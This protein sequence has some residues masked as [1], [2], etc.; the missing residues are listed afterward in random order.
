MAEQPSEWE[1][2]CV[3]F[4]LGAEMTC[5]LAVVCVAVAVSV[6]G[7]LSPVEAL[8]ALALSALTTIH[9]TTM[10]LRVRAAARRSR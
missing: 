10:L 8:A 3:G 7:L 5:A 4:W 6:A 1:L 2:I 9:P